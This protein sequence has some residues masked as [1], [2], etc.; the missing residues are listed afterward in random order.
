MIGESAVEPRPDA[1]AE[2]LA[3]LVD[4]GPSGRVPDIGGPQVVQR[5]ELI[6]LPADFYFWLR[7]LPTHR[8]KGR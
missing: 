5:H 8:G 7:F 3:D 6:P 2:R 4:A 1:V